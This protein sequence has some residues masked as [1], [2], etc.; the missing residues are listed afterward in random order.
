ML[1][2]IDQKF[3]DFKAKERKAFIAYVTAGV[4]SVSKTAEIILGLERS[5]VDM[6]EIGIPFSDPLAD[7]QTIQAA[8]KRALD[9]GT[10]L[11]KI[12]NM[13]KLLRRQTNIPL[14][15]MTY[16]NPIF[17]MGDAKFVS[18]CKAIGIDGLII[19]D[20]PPEEAINL[21]KLCQ[22]KNIATVFF[23]APTSENDRIKSN[24]AA[25]TGFVYY[26]A[27]TGVTG[28]AQAESLDVNK[29]ILHA[30]KFT[31]KPICAGFG[32][33]TPDQVKAIAQVADG[34]IVGSAIVKKIMEHSRDKNLVTI[35]STFVASLSKALK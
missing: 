24:A 16:Y 19:P 3:K 21:R 23:I 1:N 26:V 35:V 5:G 6:V 29:A 28:N 7:G 18:M 4:P 2:R 32:I 17:H 25:S 31:T 11:A 14:L 27:L 9:N 20:L 13:V 10:T 15:F 12:F 22:Q 33:N 8:S 30:K 34:V